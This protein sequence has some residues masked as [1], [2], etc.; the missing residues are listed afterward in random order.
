MLT[1]K[2]NEAIQLYIEC[3][4]KTDIAKRVGV[5][6]QTTY[7]CMGNEEFKAMISNGLNDIKTEADF[8]ITKGGI[9]RMSLN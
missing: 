9:K 7:N 2:P 6:R 8:K 3:E 1:H 4:S 5:S